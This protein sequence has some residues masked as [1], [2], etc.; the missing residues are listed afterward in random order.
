VNAAI[1]LIVSA[2]IAAAPPRQALDEPRA[3]RAELA[4]GTVIAG[5]MTAWDADGFEGSFGRHEWVQLRAADTWRLFRSVMD[6]NSAEQWIALGKAMLQMDSGADEAEQ[7]FAQALKLDQAC[8]PLIK[9]ARAEVRSIQDAAERERQARAQQQLRTIDPEGVDWPADVWTEPAPEERAAAV[10]EMRDAADAIMRDRALSLVPVET[11][12]ALVYSDLPRP[13]VARLALTLEKSY[14]ELAQLFGLPTDLSQTVL[15]GPAVVFIFKERDRFELLEAGRFNQLV[16]RGRQA[17]CHCEEERIFII[18]CQEP[19][20]D[21]LAAAVI[22]QFVHG[23]MHRVI[24][25]RRLPAWANEGLGWWIADRMLKDSKSIKSMRQRGLTFIRS[26]GHVG[27]VMQ[28]NYADG[29]FPGDGRIGDAVGLLIVQL[30]IREKQREFVQWVRAIKLGKNWVESLRDDYG[31][32][33]STFPQ[34][35]SQFYM[36]ND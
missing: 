31:V 17:M 25:P 3:I 5:R 35:I 7:A 22:C 21:S 11:P 15:H 18:A 19:D 10:Q 27:N 12:L 16:P 30:M 8:Q 6:R 2:L 26:G 28:M 23:V 34:T 29:S 24:S 9:Q 1:V 32:E 13:D 14:L 36:V 33:P 20:E 4:D